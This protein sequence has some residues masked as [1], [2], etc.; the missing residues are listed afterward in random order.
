MKQNLG[1]V[2]TA[3]LSVPILIPLPYYLLSGERE[4]AQVPSGKLGFYPIHD[5]WPD[6]SP[7]T[8]KLRNAT[9]SMIQPLME[10]CSKTKKAFHTITGFKD[11]RSLVGRG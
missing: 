8:G 3:T 11:R 10:R 1:I 7:S 6:F 9:D 2:N 5:C 4:Q